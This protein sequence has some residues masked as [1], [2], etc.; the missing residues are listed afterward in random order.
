MAWQDR[1]YYRDRGYG[2]SGNPLMWLLS[3]SVSL[4]TWFGINVRMHASM[5]LVI[6]L[7]LIFPNSVWGWRN[8][9]DFVLVLFCIVLLHE[10]GH[11][12]GSRMVGGRPS[13]IMMT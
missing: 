7:T 6:A 2:S 9:W 8:A 1:S 13:Q 4:G 10:F 5:I 11:C 12:V 3:G